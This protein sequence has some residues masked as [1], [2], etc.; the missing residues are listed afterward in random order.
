MHDTQ[1]LMR[2]GLADDDVSPLFLG[3]FP[4]DKIP[5]FFPSK[6]WCLIGNT[7]PAD[8]GGQHWIAFGSRWGKFF[9][10]ILMERNPRIISLIGTVLIV[11]ITANKICNSWSV[12]CAEIGVCIGASRSAVQRQKISYQIL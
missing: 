10:L 1:Q 5:I 4:A 9:F 8:K 2:C 3:V 11:G 12:M 7:D 6:D